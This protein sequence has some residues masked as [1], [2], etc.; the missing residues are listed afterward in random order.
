MIFFARV[1]EIR[2]H[3]GR[4]AGGIRP[5]GK[6]VAAPYCTGHGKMIYYP[7]FDHLLGW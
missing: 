5:A 4:W 6:K 7:K 1:R 3:G 2:W